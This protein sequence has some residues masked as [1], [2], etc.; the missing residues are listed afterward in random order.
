MTSSLSTSASSTS[1]SSRSSSQH[2]LPSWLREPL[3]H[4]VVLGGLLFVIDHYLVS[5]KDDPHTIVVGSDVDAEALQVFEKERGRKP[6]DA[7]LTALHQIWLDNEVL[8]REGLAMQVDKGDDVMRERVIFKALSMIEAGVKLPN[9]DDKQ[10]REWFEKHRVKYDEPKRY[11]FEEAVL[12]G[13]AS[14][15]AVRDF[16]AQLNSGTPGDAQAGLRVFKDRPHDNLVQSYSADFPKLLEEAQPGTWQA[17]ETGQAW[18]AIKVDSVIE[19]KPADFEILRGVVLQD[20]K[21][22]TASEQRTAAVRQMAKKYK[23][24]FEERANVS[25]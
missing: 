10:L 6:S 13:E 7:E 4:F 12:S 5:R 2:G 24:S 8:Y 19:S 17:V 14:E 21:D 9:I 3:L 16:V 11:N 22:A 15:A 20:W 25:K 23:I 1:A 18:H